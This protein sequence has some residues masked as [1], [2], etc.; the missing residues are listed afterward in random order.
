MTVS[1]TAG[2]ARAQDGGGGY[3]DLVMLYEQGPRGDER[4][5]AYRVRN[6]GTATAVGVTVSFL[7]EDLAGTGQKFR[8]LR[9]FGSITGVETV[10]A[11]DQRFAWVVGNLPP[12]G[13]TQNDLTFG[14]D[15]HP[16]HTAPPLMGVINARASSISPEPFQLQANNV[17]KVYAHIGSPASTLAAH[18]SGG[19]L[20]LLLSVDDLRPDAGGDVNFDLT[21]HNQN[22][23]A[24]YLGVSDSNLIAD[25]KVQVE[26]SEG[27]EFKSGWTPPDTFVKSGSQTA[28]WSPPNTDQ[29]VPRISSL[30]KYPISQQI[31]IETQLTS[32]SLDSIPLEERCITARV[33]DSIPP[34]EPDYPTGSLKE[35]LGD[36]PPLLLEE[37]SVAI[38]TSFPCIDDTHT[39]AHQCGS[40]PGVAVA[41]RVPSLLADLRPG[42]RNDAI[43]RSQGVG[44]TDEHNRGFD[45]TAFL[46]P[47]SVFIQVKDPEG[48]V[49]DSHTESVSAVS[50][51]TARPAISGKN[52]AVDGVTITYTR[53]DVKD[54]SAWNSLG[55]RTLTVTRADGTTPGKVKIRFNSSGNTSFDLST[56]TFTRNP[57]NITSTRH[58]T[59][60][61]FAEFETL[62]TYLIKYD[63]TMTDSSNTAY[64]DSA[65]YTFHVG[66][67]AELAVRDGGASVRVPPGQRAFTIVAVNNGPDAAPAAQVTVT[68]LNA[69][70][71]V[72]HSATAGRF[73]PATGVW[74][75]G[76]LGLAEHRLV[77]GQREGEIL[78]IITSAAEI[79]AEIE[80][81]QDYQVCI[82]SSA[83]DVPATSESACAGAGNT[84]HSTE[85]YDYIDDNDTGIVIAARAGTGEGDP[86]TPSVRAQPYPQPPTAVLW[87]DPVEHVNR[88]QVSHYEV[89]R[90]DPSCGL[91]DMDDTPERVD[92]T[93]FVDDLGPN[94]FDEPVCYYVRAVNNAGVPGYWSAPVELEGDTGNGRGVT[95]TPRDLTVAEDGGSAAYTV[96]LTSQ[97]PAP[98]TIIPATDDHNVA[99]VE[100]ARSDNALIFG[101]DN[102]SIPQTVTVTGVNDD[103][104]NLQNRRGTAIRHSVAG[105]GYGGVRV[106]SV[107]VTVTDDDETNPGPNRPPGVTVSRSQL[108]VSEDGGVATYTVSLNSEPSEDVVV[109]ARIA[110]G[111]HNPGAATLQRSGAAP[112]NSATLLFTT[113]NWAAPQTVTVTGQDDDLDNSNDQRTL[114]ITHTARGGGY[115]GGA[116]GNPV[117][118]TVVDDDSGVD[119]GGGP[120]IAFGVTL[121]TAALAMMEGA[122]DSSSVAL[123][124]EPLSSSPVRIQVSS[125]ATDVATVAPMELVFTTGNWKI[126]QTVT[127]TGVDD[128]HAAGERTTA[129]THIISGGGYRGVAIPDMPVTVG[130]DDVRQIVVSQ[131]SREVA[132]A[133]GKAAYT[134]ALTSPP[135]DS[136]PVTVSLDTSGGAIAVSPARVRFTTSNW[137]VPQPVTVTGVDDDIDNPDN[138]RRASISHTASGG[139]YGEV[140]VDGVAVTV[141]DDD[142]F[143]VTISETRLYVAAYRGEKTYT[144]RLNSRPTHDVTLEI[145]N[146]DRNLFISANRRQT[147]GGLTHDLVFTPGRWDQAKEIEITNTGGPSGTH[148]LRHRTFS[149]D[150]NYDGRSW[151]NVEI[152]RVRKPK[153]TVS[154]PEEPVTAGSPADFTV[155]IDGQPLAYDLEV[156]LTVIDGYRVMVN[157]DQ[158]SRRFTIPAGQ[159]Q[160][161][162]RFPTTVGTM[163]APDYRCSGGSVRVRVWVAGSRNY[164]SDNVIATPPVIAT[165]HHPQKANCGR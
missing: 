31:V 77:T 47:E 135:D 51:Q 103:I 49:Q 105:G 58:T 115:A 96:A 20:A 119:D 42:N 65:T 130:D 61:Y 142:T 41:A 118:V 30:D 69:S 54:A 146:G 121:S 56:G 141:L 137:D 86:G 108:L 129:I 1:L 99:T 60:P 92:S 122:R 127:V 148:I 126:P 163:S 26:L 123:N 76:E 106:A 52:R 138:R 46:D 11:T 85:Y 111:S 110:P 18:I 117:A 34:P 113:T 151:P 84:W 32:D 161:T 143:G 133:G 156:T 38:L 91:P 139:G 63:L 37:G 107:S 66:P 90:A 45:R 35:C 97:P 124:A 4:E 10:N 6:N 81:T 48:R 72:S 98:V 165:V 68:G 50:W 44:R 95:V 29:D 116:V 71:Y 153:V 70:D 36:D 43:L 82:D 109:T 136:G 23:G 112:G 39:D 88:W 83:N 5:I 53:K 64:T 100:T 9:D 140:A 8:D 160:A 12:G 14:T 16:S 89:W 152:Q 21:A 62:G 25:A 131:A 3:V 28:I 57:F 147:Q 162:A 125:N 114:R 15:R 73:D 158:E 93:V 7:L 24:S 33:V 27:L 157:E 144:V 80:N 13:I 17:I 75:I 78:T 19:K 134:L 74:T 2:Q 94:G 67:I 104:D 132:E 155:S 101:Q 79:T 120:E 22:T 154:A 59:S 145:V 128:Q 87:W 40:V 55:P 164:A 150:E 102:W 159:T 149:A